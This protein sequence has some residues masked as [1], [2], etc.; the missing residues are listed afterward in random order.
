MENLLINWDVLR[1][2][3][4]CFLK[5]NLA[6]LSKRPAIDLSLFA[7]SVELL[8]GGEDLLCDNF[9]LSLWQVAHERLGA[10]RWSVTGHTMMETRHTIVVKK[11]FL[12]SPEIEWNARTQRETM[13]SY[14]LG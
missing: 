2:P 11:L 8:M 12:S 3:S 5:E 6:Y 14:I 9:H 4:W 1:S 7:L 13:T 10:L